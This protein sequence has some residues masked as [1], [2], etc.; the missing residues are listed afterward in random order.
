MKQ[1][2]ASTNTRRY[3]GNRWLAWARAMR[4]RRG[5]PR[6]RRAPLAMRFV[7]RLRTLVLVHHKAIREVSTASISYHDA[8]PVSLFP[9]IDL[10]FTNFLSTVLAQ[11][12]QTA[13]AVRV[14]P[15][16]LRTGFSAGA[17]RTAND[18]ASPPPY[19]VA[20]PRTHVSMQ[21]VIERTRRV[22]H[23]IPPASRILPRVAIQPVETVAANG[24]G[25]SMPVMDRT[26]DAATRFR[27]PAAPVQINVEQI[28]DHVL[29][30]LDH[31]I[32]AWRERTGRS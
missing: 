17:Q 31:R 20:G 9:R 30:Q 21:R 18:S 6:L 8:T 5:L 16:V 10:H 11:R 4:E 25:I 27:P 14:E 12:F 15:G 2:I 13:F 7:S 24:R 29:R 23:C 19:Y 26:P 22:E 28:T 3:K 1:L 32:L